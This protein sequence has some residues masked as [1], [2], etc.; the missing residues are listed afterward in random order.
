[1]AVQVSWGLD[2]STSA[3]K[4]VK[5]RIIKEEVLLEET[6][7]INFSYSNDPEVVSGNIYN[8]FKTFFKKHST[9]GA[10]VV[11]SLPVH[12]HFNRIIQLPP[13]TPELLHQTIQLEAHQHI[14]FPLDEVAWDYQIIEREYGP[15]EPVDV[16][17][18]VIKWNFLDDFLRYLGNNQLKISVI[19]F[20][21]S[22]VFNFFRFTAPSPLPRAI[23][24][25]GGDNTDFIVIE[26]EKFWYRN[27]P[28]SGYDF[29]RLIAEKMQIS[30]EEA[31]NEKVFMA[32][33]QN[34]A[35]LSEI[36]A[37][38]VRDITT[39]VSRS[40]GF[41]KS[42]SRRAKF[43]ELTLLG[44]GSK[45]HGLDKAIQQSL[46]LKLVKNVELTN[47]SYGNKINP[48]EFQENLGSF[49]IATGLAL[50]GLE[51]TENRVNLYPFD[52]QRKKEL[53]KKKP[54]VVVATLIFALFAF[55]ISSS[56]SKG[57]ANAKELKVKIIGLEPE[58]DESGRGKEGIVQKANNLRKE[59]SQY[60]DDK[61][62]E[63]K[64]KEVSQTSMYRSVYLKILNAVNE[65]FEK[66]IK[67]LKDTNSLGNREIWLVKLEVT[68]DTT[69]KECSAYSPEGICRKFIVKAWF[70]FPMKGA[71]GS[72]STARDK[73]VRE[74]V[75]PLS[76]KICEMFSLTCESPE[77]SEFRFLYNSTYKSANLKFQP[78]KEGGS[79]Q[80][81]FSGWGSKEEENYYIFLYNANLK[82]Y[83]K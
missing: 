19:Q 1:M 37:P 38:K 82:L 58:E 66:Y 63:E 11:C 2:V 12:A 67:N 83:E 20:A 17:L 70:G 47:I 33:S 28:I 68:T 16:A 32:N 51:L 26:G 78:K 52:L 60:S 18:F 14:P 21:P 65:E 13:S 54:W 59:Y 43:S 4:A 27:I 55:I 64:L 53:N 56:I 23:L 3:I 69:D 35:K 25:I 5:L 49:I 8:G 44:N 31:E 72:E 81:M 73:I 9:G 40:I 45:L 61:W 34:V 15:G 57:V 10:N 22:A 62:L 41:Y 39:E 77:K 71:G 75:T 48:D 80:D 36:I 50:Q 6:D 46:G 7:T 74:I 76:K 42:I 30:F 29:T 24:D 79:S